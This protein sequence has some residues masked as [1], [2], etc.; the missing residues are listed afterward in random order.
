MHHQLLSMQGVHLCL[1]VPNW[2]PDGNAGLMCLSQEQAALDNCSV[3]IFL[4]DFDTDTSTGSTC[5]VRP[6]IGA[7]HG[8]SWNS[9]SIL[10]LEERL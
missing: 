3:A 7:L 5:A 2:Q 9:T 4:Q 10:D 1:F 8:N 6:I